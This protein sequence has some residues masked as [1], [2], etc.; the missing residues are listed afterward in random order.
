MIIRQAQEDFGT[1]IPAR[2]H[3]GEAGLVVCACRAEVNDFYAFELAVREEDIF[4]LQVTV[5]NPDIFEMIQS[6]EHLDGDLLEQQ[7]IKCLKAWLLDVL[8]QV[9]VKELK[10]DYEV[11]P[12]REEV[13]HLH[14]AVPI[15][16]FAENFLEQFYLDGSIFDL[17]PLL[18]GDLQ[19]HI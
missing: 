6:I 16:V 4:W 2:L 18:F 11:M 17:S 14:D 3:V 19:R 13:Q 5:N 7:A 9:D 15:R 12:E 8:V 1:S 10:D